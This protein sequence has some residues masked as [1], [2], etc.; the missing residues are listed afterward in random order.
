M[1]WPQGNDDADQEDSRRRKSFKARGNLENEVEL[2]TEQTEIIEADMLRQDILIYLNCGVILY[3]LSRGYL[4][5]LQCTNIPRSPNGK[6]QL[7]GVRVRFK[8]VTKALLHQFEE[9]ECKIAHGDCKLSYRLPFWSIVV[10]NC[11]CCSLK[12]T[13]TAVL[14]FISAAEYREMYYLCV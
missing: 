5:V 1:A 4:F 2:T 10:Y 14:V 12:K 3:I 9:S 7:F 8:K 11:Q 13:N 6:T